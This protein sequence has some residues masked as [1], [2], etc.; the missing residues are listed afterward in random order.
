MEMWMIKLL[1]MS[2]SASVC[3]GIT[4]V[5]RLFLRG[6]PKKYSCIL[7]FP[8]LFRLLCPLSVPAPFGILPRS[9]TV[10]LNTSGLMVHM[11][12]SINYIQKYL[13]IFGCL[14]AA[15]FV[16]FLLFHMYRYGKMRKLMA[17]AVRMEDGIYESESIGMPVVSGLL[18]PR[19]YLPSAMENEERKY[20]IAHERMHIKRGDF[21]IKPLAF[22]A[23]CLHWMNP[24]VWLFFK[25]FSMD[26]EMACDEAAVRLTGE[27]NKKAY[28]LALLH[29]AEKNSSRTSSLAFGESHT[30][31]RVKNILKYKSVKRIPAAL[32]TIGAAAF[33]IVLSADNENAVR[34]VSVIGGADGPT[35][36]FVAGKID[37]E[38]QAEDILKEIELMFEKILQ[39]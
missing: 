22:L 39:K 1:Y 3:I 33:A 10:Y 34:A 4:V 13:L 19:I 16:S 24:F 11:G 7:W 29:F 17:L 12:E 23:L 25:L 35:S 32:L 31:S 28:S 21:L 9:G 26:M 36:V 27:E 37:G 30:K 6:F 20:I 14:W 18:H 2:F 8:A 15:G 38:S 5:V